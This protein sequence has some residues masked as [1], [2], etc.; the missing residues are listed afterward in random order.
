MTHEYSLSR[1]QRA[2]VGARKSG[3]ITPSAMFTALLLETFADYGT[4]RNAC[5]AADT[6]AD[7]QGVKRDT[8]YRNLVILRQAGLVDQ[9]RRGGGLNGLPSRFDLVIP[10]TNSGDSAL[11]KENSGGNSGGNSGADRDTTSFTSFTSF[12]SIGKDSGKDAHA[13]REQR[14]GLAAQKMSQGQY[15]FFQSNAGDAQYGSIPGKFFDGRPT[16]DGSTYETDAAA[17]LL[18]AAADALEEHGN[19][20]DGL[21]YLCTSQAL[22]MDD[23]QFLVRVLSAYRDPQKFSR[24]TS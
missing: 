19:V 2:V 5:P 3:A 4:G 16:G 14:I 17:R 23:A 18:A 21:A 15:E 12:T 1:W 7:L 22:A 8:I 11:Q 24:A 20:V 13:S 10:E 9:T 6:L